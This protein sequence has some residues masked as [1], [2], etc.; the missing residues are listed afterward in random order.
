MMTSPRHRNA[1]KLYN[2]IR[3]QIPVFDVHINYLQIEYRV[4][5]KERI[6]LNIHDDILIFLMTGRLRLKKILRE[7]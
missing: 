4:R 2:T 6:P 3:T 5:Y 7:L 1:I